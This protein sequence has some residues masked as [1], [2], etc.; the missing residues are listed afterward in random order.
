MASSFTGD[1]MCRTHVRLVWSARVGH[2]PKKPVF[3][4][5]YKVNIGRNIEAANE[6]HINNL[7]IKLPNEDLLLSVHNHAF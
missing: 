4:A 2:W 1:S 6:S 7:L 5:E 3:A